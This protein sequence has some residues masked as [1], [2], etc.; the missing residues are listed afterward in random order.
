MSKV[1]EGMSEADPIALL[2]KPDDVST[3]KDWGRRSADTRE[4]WRYGASGHMAVALGRLGIDE[5]RKVVWVIGRGT[6]P[7]EGLFT[8]PELRKLLEALSRLPA[9]S[10]GDYNR[11]PVIRVVNLLQPLGKEK[12]LA[13]IDEFLRVS[14]LRTDRNAHEGVFLV[15]RTLF[16]VPT[17]PTVFPRDHDPSPPGFMPPMRIGIANLEEPTDRKLLPRYPIVIEGDIPFLLCRGG[18]MAGFPQLARS[19]VQYFRK[20][21]TPRA[22][23]LAPSDR[24]FEALQTLA[25]YPRWS[26]KNK[27]DQFHVLYYRKDELRV[28]LGNQVLRLL[29]TV[30]RFGVDDRVGTWRSPTWDATTSGLSKPRTMN[31]SPKRRTFRSGGTAR[32]SNIR[33]STERSCR[34]TSPWLIQGCRGRQALE[35]RA[36]NSFFDAKADSMSKSGRTVGPRWER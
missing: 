6:P 23:P 14:S 33:F 10:E 31:S 21:G 19:H 5:N 15:L 35:S 28:V 4:T 1:K 16:E 18:G 34:R 3:E 9:V 27:S 25:R 26:F 17:M 20:Y 12:A 13:A 24:P 30:H 7:P 36:S 2:G 11:R 29:D 32:S 8:E 22:K